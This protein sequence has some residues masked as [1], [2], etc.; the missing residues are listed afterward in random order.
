MTDTR[1]PDQ[2][3][4]DIAAATLDR[5]ARLDDELDSLKSQF[6]MLGRFTYDADSDSDKD[7]GLQLLGVAST[8]ELLR[9][10]GVKNLVRDVA[11]KLP[12]RGIDY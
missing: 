11:E 6:A 10:E 9:S 1:S 7:K 12:V 3:M 5:L 8:L 2:H 4:S